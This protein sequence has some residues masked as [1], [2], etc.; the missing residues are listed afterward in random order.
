[1]GWML[2]SDAMSTSGRS[3]IVAQSRLLA[4]KDPLGRN[5]N[6]IWESYVVGDGMTWDTIKDSESTPNSRLLLDWWNLSKNRPALNFQAQRKAYKSLLTDGELHYILFFGPLGTIPVIRL[7]EDSTEFIDPITHPD[8]RATVLYFVR[9]YSPESWSFGEH[10]PQK[11]V[12]TEERFQYIKAWDADL[13]VLKE[14]GINPPRADILQG[15][16]AIR[17]TINES[18]SRGFPMNESALDWIRSF[19][20]FMEDRVTISRALSRFAWRLTGK[21]TETQ[22]DSII[23]E[24]ENKKPDSDINA[25]RGVGK[26]FGSNEK[27]KLEALR[28]PSGGA[29]SRTDAR[30][31]RQMAGA[32]M[33]ITEPNL[34]GDPSVG[35]LA[36]LTAMDGSMHRNF[37]TDQALMKDTWRDVFSAV[38]TRGKADPRVIEEAISWVRES[39]DIDFPVIVAQDLK[40]Y[41]DAVS[42]LS[43]WLPRE[44]ISKNALVA[45]GEKNP[46]QVLNEL[47]MPEPP[48]QENRPKPEGG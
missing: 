24:I 41:S 23:S 47:G 20:G 21:G 17:A 15:A 42:V 11:T 40:I 12:E 36:S 25:G 5:A 44:W 13:T 34:T 30:L 6:R 28:P 4:R 7:M 22:I 3:E 1:M 48:P 9:R 33:G 26:I 31:I 38:I 29:D 46:E 10:G 45:F 43:P 27:L 35:N 14:A 39:L 16:L 2:L 37:S 8:D 32:G 18:L 19:K